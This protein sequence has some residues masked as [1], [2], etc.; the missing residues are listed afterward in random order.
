MPNDAELL[1]ALA[2]AQK[3]EM[4]AEL[5]RNSLAYRLGDLL[6]ETLRDGRSPLRLVGRVAPS[7][8]AI[9]DL[10]NLARI[11]AALYAGL[12]SQAAPLVHL[13]THHA[14]RRP[15]RLSSLVRRY[16]PSPA[17]TA[18]L[19]ELAATSKADWLKA[20]ANRAIELD[21]LAQEGFPLPPRQPRRATAAEARSIIYLVQADPAA[22]SN[23]Y[24]R[25]THE[26]VT[27]L[28][29]G[30]WQVQALVAPTR[31]ASPL[32]VTFDGTVYNRL[33]GAASYGDGLVGYI[34]IYAAQIERIALA[35]KASLIHAA[36]T[37][38]NGLAG[39][40]AAYRLGLP[41]IYE[42][43]GLWELTRLTLTPEFEASLG[44]A[45]QARLER[46][47]AAAADRVLILGRELGE[48]LMRRG[49]PAD[50][51]TLAPSGAHHAVPATPESRKSARQALGLPATGTETVIGYIGSLA[52][53][54]GLGTLVL[55]FTKVAEKLPDARLIIIGDGAE[56]G[57]LA[58]LIERS[59]L[60]G[61]VLLPGAVRAEHARQAYAALDIAVYARERSRVTEVVPPLKH[62]EAAASGVA[63][64]VSDIAPLATFANET[65]AAL[66]VP[67]GDPAALAEALLR[68]SEDTALRSRLA[69]AGRAAA[70]RQTWQQTADII[71]GVY[72]DVLG[73]PAG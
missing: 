38:L 13:D 39:A 19:I 42:V 34:E 16:R 4:E 68:L 21:R 24:T 7:L 55:A 43:R 54:E 41:F 12:P 9:W 48:E 63:M 58:G 29:A 72:R 22:L 51:L 10:A 5:L 61:R 28:S 70:A 14:L 44:F 49:A 59:G 46:D 64:V 35:T 32:P 62:L 66:T 26:I 25:R 52:S 31:L 60:S 17:T 27:R 20:R 23:G 6:L 36:S 57:R 69:K 65:G 47:A 45:T 18:A 33:A 71:G 67:A 40:L 73:M 11:D 8:G 2:R 53:Y 15:A 37:F 3:A 30:G 56:R 50:N 1:S